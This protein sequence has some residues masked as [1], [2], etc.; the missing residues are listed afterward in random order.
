MGKKYFLVVYFVITFD[1]GIYGRVVEMGFC[2][3]NILDGFWVAGVGD[4]VV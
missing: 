4:G 3:F 1:I 2:F